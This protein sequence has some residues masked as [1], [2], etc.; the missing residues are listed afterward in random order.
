MGYNQALNF[1]AQRQYIIDKTN[2]KLEYRDTI[3]CPDC[4]RNTKH[5]FMKELNK[6]IC[7]FCYMKNK[8]E[9][10]EKS[11]TKEVNKD[12]IDRVEHINKSYL[13]KY[14]IISNTNY[15]DKTFYEFRTNNKPKLN[16][17]KEPL[18]QLTKQILNGNHFTVVLYSNESGTGKTHLGFSMLNAINDNSSDWGDNNKQLKCLAVSFLTLADKIS[19]SITEG[20]NKQGYYLNLIKDADVVLLDDVGAEKTSDFRTSLLFDILESRAETK[21]TIITTNLNDNQLLNKYG[22]RVFSR[23]NF[24]KQVIDFSGLE[25]YRMNKFK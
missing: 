17:V 14:S 8:N 3:Y 1:E 6:E 9:E 22:Q 23:M 15:F 16:E 25:D 21:T 10:Q 13:K 18:R 2:G 12:R 11:I 20:E 24:N 5:Y 4:K 19:Q 7:G